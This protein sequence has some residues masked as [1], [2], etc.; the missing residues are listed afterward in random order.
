M[1]SSREEAVEL[2]RKTVEAVGAEPFLNGD[3][4]AELKKKIRTALLP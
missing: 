1:T 4:T 2:I 3:D